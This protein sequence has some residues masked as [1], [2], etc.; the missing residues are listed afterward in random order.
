MSSP[1]SNEQ[2]V[3]IPPDR[4]LIFL[5]VFPYSVDDLWDITEIYDFPFEKKKDFF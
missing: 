4:Q 1:S 2:V 3:K 5:K